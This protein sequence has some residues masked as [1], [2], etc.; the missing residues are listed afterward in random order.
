[1]PERVEDCCRRVRAFLGCQPPF[2]LCLYQFCGGTGIEGGGGGGAVQTANT[3]Y[4]SSA[5]IRAAASTNTLARIP[6]LQTGQL[7]IKIR[8]YIDTVA[9]QA[10]SSK[11]SARRTQDIVLERGLTA[12]DTAFGVER[13]ARRLPDAK[14]GGITQIDL[15]DRS[16]HM[17]G[18]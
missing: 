12:C 5:T 9:A 2:W 8:P 13:L 14:K 11:P 7:V 4:A 6:T 1:M 17:R 3:T 10:I 16:V 15:R 18:A